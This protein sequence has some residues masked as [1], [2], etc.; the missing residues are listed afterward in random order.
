MRKYYKYVRSI[1][2]LDS[3]KLFEGNL[4]IKYINLFALNFTG[5]FNSFNF[6]IIFPDAVHTIIN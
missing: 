6:F 5:F 3:N 2:M 1:R 4:L